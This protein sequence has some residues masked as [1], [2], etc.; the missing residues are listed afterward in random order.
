MPTLFVKVSSKFIHH[1]YSLCFVIEYNVVGEKDKHKHL[2]AVKYVKPLPVYDATEYPLKCDH[3]WKRFK[4]ASKKKRHQDQVHTRGKSRVQ[5][6]DENNQLM[7]KLHPTPKP[8][9]QTN[10]LL[11]HYVKQHEL[12][13]LFFNGIDL[14]GY[15]SKFADTEKYEEWIWYN[16]IDL[17]QD[18][19]ETTDA[20]RPA[21]D[22]GLGV[23]SFDPHYAAPATTNLIERDIQEQKKMLEDQETA[24]D[25]TLGNHSQD[26]QYDMIPVNSKLKYSNVFEGSSEKASVTKT[27]TILSQD[28]EDDVVI[29]VRKQGKLEEKGG[30]LVYETN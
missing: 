19:W 8:F 20:D 1:S 11:E 2:A 22:V 5:R 16:G 4:Y 24:R 17:R 15:L 25:T 26:S 18:R 13:E 10:S 12:R 9:Q 7:C 28:T 29:D 6:R 14:E 21:G 3:C 23:F 30:C 27:E